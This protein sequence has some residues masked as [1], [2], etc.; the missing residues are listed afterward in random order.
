MI[1]SANNIADTLA[2][3]AFGDIGAYS[4]YANEFLQRHGLVQT[5]VGLDASG[6]DPSTTSSATDLARLGLLARKNPVLMQIAGQKNV[7]LPY[8]GEYENYNRALGLAG[9]NGLKTGNNDQNPGALLFTADL[10]LGQTKIQLSG[11]VMGAESLQDAIDKSVK[12]V[13]S[14]ED[15]FEKVIVAGQ[16]EQVGTLVTAWGKT[17]PVLVKGELAIVRW[18]PHTIKTRQTLTQTTGTH[19]QTV[20]AIALQ[21]GETHTSTSLYLNQPATNPSLWWRLTRLR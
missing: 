8:A 16:N 2:G 18:K 6:L 17:V 12:V 1:P 5:H 14:L 7:V 15:D 10:P 19:S 13:S 4:T 21:T 9:I 11:A 20:G 3:W